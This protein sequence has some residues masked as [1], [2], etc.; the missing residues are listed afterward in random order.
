MTAYP[1]E[2]R[3]SRLEGAFEQVVERLGDMNARLETLEM[4]TAGNYHALDEK[5]SA[6]DANFESKFAALDAKFESKFAA[7]D[8]KFESKFTAM[9]SKFESSFAATDSK[10]DSKFNF[11]V[12]LYVS[13]TLT[14]VAVVLAVV[15]PLYS[16]LPPLH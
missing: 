16:R 11:L 5:I 9:D 7:L 15:L 1:W 6:L 2:P 12:G 10:F 8:A 4:K 14:I 3:M 13:S